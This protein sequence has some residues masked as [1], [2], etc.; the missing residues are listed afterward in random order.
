MSFKFCLYSDIHGQIPQL[1]AVE[2][3]VEKE[4][5]DKTVVIGDLVG[6]GPEPG[7]IVQRMM[8]LHP[9]SCRQLRHK[10]TA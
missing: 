2:A 5:P 10:L 9:N 3:E 6:L 8:D 1:D 7:D 4:N